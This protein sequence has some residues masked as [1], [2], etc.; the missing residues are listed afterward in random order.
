MRSFVLLMLILL[1]ATSH[2]VGLRQTQIQ[3]SASTSALQSIV[4]LANFEDIPADIRQFNAQLLVVNALEMVESLI[5]NKLDAAN[6][7][8]EAQAKIIAEQELAKLNPS[9]EEL[10]KLR[11][12][13]MQLGMQ[14]KITKLPAVIINHCYATEQHSVR[15]ALSEWERAPCE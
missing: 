7:T 12:D 2:A 14:F 1:A 15:A 4:V 3:K 8:D 11:V 13:A 10:A 9:L 6:I 5:N